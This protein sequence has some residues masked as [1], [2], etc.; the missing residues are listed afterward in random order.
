MGVRAKQVTYR[1]KL[2]NLGCLGWA[3]AGFGLVLLWAMAPRLGLALVASLLIARLARTAWRW[4]RL[5][6]HTVCV[7]EHLLVQR[8]AN[9]SEVA[10][11]DLSRPIIY[12]YID[13]A[14]GTAILELSQGATRLRFTTSL[15]NAEEVTSEVLGLPWPVRDAA[16][17]DQF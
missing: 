6:D 3:V 2:T 8:D 12:Q 16:W 14:P 7:S 4:Q 13:R 5:K 15:S 1:P 9:G 11:I 10:R 17:R